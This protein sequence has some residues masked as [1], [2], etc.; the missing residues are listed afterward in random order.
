MSKV[1]AQRAMREARYVAMLA[2]A[3]GP[4]PAPA[5][6]ASRTAPAPAAAPVTP[7]QESAEAADLCGHRSIGNKSCQRPAGHSEKNHRYR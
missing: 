6:A 7:G 2:V 5:R 1:D 3:A 4:R